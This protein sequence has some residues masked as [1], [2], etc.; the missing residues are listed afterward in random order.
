MP[1]REVVEKENWS[2][3]FEALESCFEITRPTHV[4]ADYCCTCCGGEFMPQCDSSYSCGS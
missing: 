4:S 3:V 1:K 2:S